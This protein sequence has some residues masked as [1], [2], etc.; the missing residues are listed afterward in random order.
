MLSICT[1]ILW[2][3]VGEDD[4]IGYEKRDGNARKE[5]KREMVEHWSVWIPTPLDVEPENKQ[6]SVCDPV[7]AVSEHSLLH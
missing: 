3:W 2:N 5:K 7:L 6:Y 4:K 1:K